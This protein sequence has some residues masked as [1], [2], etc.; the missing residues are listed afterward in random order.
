MP[1]KGCV[2]VSPHQNVVVLRQ[3]RL[4][5]FLLHLPIACIHIHMYLGLTQYGAYML[6]ILQT[7]FTDGDHHH[8]SAMH[9]LFVR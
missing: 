3:L 2:I 5:H 1:I 6:G 4:T 7:D 8:L 9:K